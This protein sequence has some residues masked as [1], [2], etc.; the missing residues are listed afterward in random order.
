MS[1]SHVTQNVN[2]PIN[3]L[4]DN[5]LPLEPRRDPRL[6]A[7]CATIFLNPKDVNRLIRGSTVNYFRRY[8]SLLE[9]KENGCPL[10]KLLVATIRFPPTG[11]RDGKL[12]PTEEEANEEADPHVEDVMRCLFTMEGKKLHTVRVASK[13]ENRRQTFA[14]VEI[15]AHQGNR[16]SRT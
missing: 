5:N 10:C 3:Q 13:R 2:N 6:C 4:P 14:F 15:S 8:R 12:V 7:S 9:S 1:A 16:Q 11:L